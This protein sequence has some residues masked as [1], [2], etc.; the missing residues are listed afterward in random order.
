[1]TPHQINQL[2]APTGAKPAA[3]DVDAKLDDYDA[4]IRMVDAYDQ[5]TREIDGA[6]AEL[7]A[8]IDTLRGQLDD[9]NRRLAARDQLARLGEISATILHE[10]R[11]PLTAIQLY[12]DMLMHDL[13]GQT[14][15]RRLVG[16]IRGAV[17][18][19]VMMTSDVMTFAKP[20]RPD[21]DRCQSG[22][23]LGR[24]IELLDSELRAHTVAVKVHDAGVAV[25]CDPQLV[26]HA[27]INLIRNAI[28][29]MPRGGTVTLVA[30][31]IDD[32]LQVLVQDTGP[33]IDAASHP[34]LFDPTFTTKHGGNGLGLAIV[35]RIAEAHG[36]VV[37][38]GNATT[39]GA[40]FTFA[41]PLLGR[42]A[43]SHE[44]SD[45]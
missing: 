22:A 39:G 1:M 31:A 35:K 21:L 32:T 17:R 18:D 37:S 12:A 20:L 41:V 6:H 8:E 44:G 40:V 13:D 5:V 9:A 36:G 28:Q 3:G 34:H 43:P 14:E 45:A 38:A 29:A 7:L 25:V 19:L 42:N 2:Q 15:Q 26:H 33:G 24:A 16:R 11:S 10:V 4:L 23:L 30:R 27:L